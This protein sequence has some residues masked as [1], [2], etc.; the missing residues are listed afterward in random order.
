MQKGDQCKYAHSL[1][2]LE[3][4]PRRLWK[5]ANTPLSDEQLKLREFYEHGE[6]HP[7][8]PQPP[9]AQPPHDE[10]KEQRKQKPQPPAEPPPRELREFPK[11]KETPQEQRGD[12]RSSA[13]IL[14]SQYPTENADANEFEVD[15][16][17]DS[18]SVGSSG[19]PNA[20]PAKSA[21]VEPPWAEDFELISVST[22]SMHMWQAMVNFRFHRWIGTGSI[23]FGTMDMGMVS[24]LGSLQCRVV[25]GTLTDLVRETQ[26]GRPFTFNVRC[27]ERGNQEER[28]YGVAPKHGQFDMS[29]FTKWC[30]NQGD[31]LFPNSEK[32]FKG[33]VGLRFMNHVLRVFR[34][35]TTAIMNYPGGDIPSVFFWCKAGKHRS[36]A[37]LI[38]WLM[39][40]T[41]CYCDAPLRAVTDMKRDISFRYHI[42]ER[43]D[44]VP[45]GM[46]LKAWT[47]CLN[48][49]PLH[50]MYKFCKG[51]TSFPNESS[52]SW[53]S[54]AASLAGHV[55]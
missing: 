28:K 33:N 35:L 10:E 52:R 50:R 8:E 20:Q 47:T 11:W 44:R 41:H 45:M 17:S 42:R 16:G 3:A 55:C 43:D 4:V 5:N 7:E 31:G 51:T 6:Q 13:S 36:P 39:W 19:D 1:K 30:D 40:L 2:E 9:A 27:R 22:D 32:D 34:S 38:A 18:P 12:K 29:A 53:V 37:I 24:A 23:D 14:L 15:H 46:F 54:C 25:L 49:D 48:R 26:A 21:R